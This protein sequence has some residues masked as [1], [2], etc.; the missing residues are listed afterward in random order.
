ML[1]GFMAA[2]FAERPKMEMKSPS[3]VIC[4]TMRTL[5]CDIVSCPE[6]VG[7]EACYVVREEDIELARRIIVQ[8]GLEVGP[9][10][11]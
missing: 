7:A 10:S 5:H 11:P 3:L 9:P 8:Q 2:V 6:Y 1:G 4:Q